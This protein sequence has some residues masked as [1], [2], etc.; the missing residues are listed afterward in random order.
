MRLARSI[1]AIFVAALMLVLLAAC[2]GTSASGSGTSTSGGSLPLFAGAKPL[3]GG[4]PMAVAIDAAKQ[5]L[6]Q[7]QSGADTTVDAYTLPSGTSFD[8]VKKFY[9][10]SLTSAGWKD[11]AGGA[12]MPAMPNGGTAVWT[13][14]DKEV[15]TV[16]VMPDP[17]GSSGA[18]LL[19]AHAT[20]K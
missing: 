10:D 4:S 20:Q 11:A 14:N 15:F 3:E 17:T 13:K 18:I 5:Q 19:V 9:S 12:A 2:G 8:Q 7:Q 1:T 16:T 6:K